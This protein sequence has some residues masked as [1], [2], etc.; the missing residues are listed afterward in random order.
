[1]NGFLK[2][3]KLSEVKEHS[4][5]HVA[6]LAFQLVS[7]W[8]HTCAGPTAPPNLCFCCHP[9]Q[10]VGE[11]GSESSVTERG[12]GVNPAGQGLSTQAQWGD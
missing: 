11:M 10:A 12:T 2:K 9:E 1:M 7:L 4:Q 6:E 8:L 3:S 5:G